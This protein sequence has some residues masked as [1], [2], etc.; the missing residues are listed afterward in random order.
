MSNYIYDCHLVNNHLIIVTCLVNNHL[1]IV[2]TAT[3]LPR[4]PP[5]WCTA[6]TSGA[7]GRRSTPTS[8]RRSGP[9]R[10][11]CRRVRSL[12]HSTEAHTCSGTIMDARRQDCWRGGTT[13][14]SLTIPHVAYTRTHTH[15]LT[16]TF[17]AAGVDN[18]TVIYADFADKKGGLFQK[19]LGDLR[20]DGVQT[21][22]V[23]AKRN[24][25]MVRGL[26]NTA[27][28]THTAH[29]LVIG[30]TQHTTHRHTQ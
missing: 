30:G 11:C 5:H 24:Y 2:I 3:R 25:M 9:S 8:H 15:T 18:Y 20:I 29:T 12:L 6:R 28:I 14:S 23:K 16:L 1:I 26:A 19:S 13:Q 17:C 10:A 21:N 4:V 27:H 7:H 22:N